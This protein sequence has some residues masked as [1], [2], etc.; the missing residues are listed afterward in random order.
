MFNQKQTEDEMLN[1]YNIKWIEVALW[2]DKYEPDKFLR[3]DLPYDITYKSN[4]VPN[5]AVFSGNFVFNHWPKNL[6][7]FQTFVQLEK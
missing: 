4:K 2:R 3:K 1:L 7:W 6:F 5:G